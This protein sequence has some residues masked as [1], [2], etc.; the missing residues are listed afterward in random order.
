MKAPPLSEGWAVDL[1][2]SPQRSDKFPTDVGCT[3]EQELTNLGG[4]ALSNHDES[5]RCVPRLTHDGADCKKVFYWTNDSIL[6]KHLS[7]GGVFCWVKY[8]SLM[9]SYHAKVNSL[10]V[11]MIA[12]RIW[13]WCLSPVEYGM[14]LCFSFT[15][16]G[17]IASYWGGDPLKEILFSLVCIL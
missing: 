1:L 11:I 10:S 9:K 17:G 15:R 3:P 6:M 5:W 2:N 8:W 7:C 13:L 14:H 12:G 4:R 16:L